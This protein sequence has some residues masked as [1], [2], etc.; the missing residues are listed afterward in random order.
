MEHNDLLRKY[1]ELAVKIGVNIQQKQTLVIHSPIECADFTRMLAEAAYEA[2]AKDVHVDWRDEELNK[3]RYAMA[4]EEAFLEFPKWI[5]EGKETLAK[6]GAAFIS[7][8]ASNP[9]LLKDIDPKRISTWNKTASNA[10]SVYR[11]HVMSSLVTWTVLSVPTKSWATKVFPDVSEDA[12]VSKLWE[13]IFNV[14]RID[15]D[16]PVEAWNQHLNILSEKVEYLNKTKFE[17]LH[18]KSN[19]TDL[20]IQLPEKHLWAG[21]GEYSKKG[22]YFVAN[23]PTEEVFTL[24]QKNGVNGTVASTKPL[25][26]N[27]NLI[28]NF[29]L[30]FKDG[31][32]V[33]YSAEQGYET[34]KELIETDEGSHYLGEVALVPYMSPIS[35]SNIIFYNTLFDENASCH[36]A[37]GKAYPTNL[38]GGDEMDSNELEQNGANTS[39][40]HVDFMIGSSDL[41]IL[42]ITKDDKEIQIFKDGN[43]AF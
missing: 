3:I 23:M 17:K 41:N 10:L 40:T 42:G 12:A 21:G 14:V 32:I 2:G 5:A 13:Q 9:E 7:I 11:D 20:M 4:P 19:K 38:E 8:S 31:R 39:L 34:L 1:A 28:D 33:D 37:I 24:P 29:T 43:W 15:K 36:L 18:F 16:D 30:T 6:E 26:H 27:G 22:T 35:N 25:N